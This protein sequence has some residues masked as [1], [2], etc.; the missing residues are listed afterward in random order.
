VGSESESNPIPPTPHSLVFPD[1]SSSSLLSSLLLVGNK[2][3][4]T[5]YKY[6]FDEK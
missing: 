6:I 4:L 1:L 5:K 2:F 3:E